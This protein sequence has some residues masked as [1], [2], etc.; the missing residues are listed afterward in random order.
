[1]IHKPS[2]NLTT[3]KTVNSIVTGSRFSTTKHTAQR[4]KH[5]KGVFALLL[6]GVLLVPEVGFAASRNTTT[7]PRK[8]N[9]CTAVDAFSGQMKNSM[10]ENVS[11]YFSKENERQS[12]LDVKLAKQEA[13][14]QSTRFTWNN[15]RDKVYTE[16]LQRA[17]SKEQKLA[18]AKFRTTIDDA[19]AVRRDTVDSAA[20]HF[21]TEI[22][23]VAK[24]RK[25]I[26]ES[27]ID[28]FMDDADTAL[29]DA[30]A[31]CANTKTSADARTNYLAKLEVA[32]KALQQ[33]LNQVKSS[34]LQQLV[35]DR[36]HAIEQAGADFKS[37]VVHAEEVLKRAFP[38][39]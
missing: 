6:L 21:K 16:L 31:D 1:M 11:R 2:N 30:H 3:R 13:D 32:Q 18:I 28:Q 10:R 15:S 20:E 4:S 5:Y 19:V 22:D 33:S 14:R 27:A 36:Q 9:F 34:G 17:T 35:S 38:D 29:A 7:T 39:A 24:N 26:I 8:V 23:H 12:A 25:T 37:A